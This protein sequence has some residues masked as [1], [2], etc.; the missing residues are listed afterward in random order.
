MQI[1][2][3]EESVRVAELVHRGF[4]GESC[5][6]TRLHH[7]SDAVDRLCAGDVDLVIAVDAPPAVDGMKTVQAIREAGVEVPFLLLGSPV[8]RGDVVAALDAGVSDYLSRPFAFSE[9]FTRI[10][11]LLEWRL[12]EPD[13]DVAVELV[14]AGTRQDLGDAPVR[15]WSTTERNADE[16]LKDEWRVD[17]RQTSIENTIIML[18]QSSSYRVDRVIDLPRLQKDCL[19]RG[20]SSQEF[21][22]GFVR[23]LSQQLLIS[24]G[25]FVY[26]LSAEGHRLV[27][28]ADSG[29]S[30]TC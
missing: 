26:C 12:P 17:T 15:Q 25:D 1:L 16:Y 14:A 19:R 23:L 3:I 29:R 10:R 13:A 22:Y 4:G 9:L 7:D 27:Q 18:L 2:V 11:A 20:F 30:E 8:D 5:R 28:Q 21:S 24:C 6:V